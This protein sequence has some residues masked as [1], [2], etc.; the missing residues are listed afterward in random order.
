MT[1]TDL[2]VIDTM[3]V[4]AMVRS[5]RDPETAAEYRDLVAG[6][7]VVVSF[8]TVT[9]VR[10]GAR[11]A[12]WGELRRRGLERTLSRMV[13]AQPVD[14]LMTVCAELRDRC[15]RRGLGLGQKVHEADR[16]IAA[17]ALYLEV[18]LVSDDAVFQGVDGLTVLSRGTRSHR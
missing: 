5:R 3:V 14:E 8:A 13:V 2:V 18:E 12:Q 1:S 10:Y 9:E 7:A 6:R 17:T 11:K 16:W 4:S 15:E